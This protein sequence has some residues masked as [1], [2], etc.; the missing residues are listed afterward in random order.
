VNFR[1]KSITKKMDTG[2]S[3]LSHGSSNAY[4]HVVVISFGQGLH[5]VP[6]K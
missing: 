1:R 2:H 5:S 3:D 6:L 4:F